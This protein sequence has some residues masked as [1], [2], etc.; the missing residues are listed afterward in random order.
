MNNPAVV[1]DRD[2][3]AVGRQELFLRVDPHEVKDGRAQVFGTTRVG[4]RA[5]G[6][7]VA[8]ADDDTAL[9][10]TAAQRHGERSTPLGAP[11]VLVDPWRAPELTGDDD[12][13]AV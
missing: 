2:R 8:L 5:L 7:G 13:R 6:A 3:A 9:N 1:D 12:E 4:G 10:P 11:R